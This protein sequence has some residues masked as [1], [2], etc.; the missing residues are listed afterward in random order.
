M[1]SNGIDDRLLTPE[2]AAT[3]LGYKT[4]TVYNKANRREIPC[5]K[6]GHTLRFRL[7][8]LDAWIAEQ[9]AAAKASKADTPESAEEGSA[10]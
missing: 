4:G 9:D 3:Y 1:T 5:V 7:S 6:L 10:A 2:E 8:E